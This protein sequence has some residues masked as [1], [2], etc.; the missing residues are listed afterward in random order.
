MSEGKIIAG[1]DIGTTKIAC[2]VGQKDSNGKI[3]I[4]GYGKTAS[5]GVTRGVVQNIDQTV[6]AIKV[7]V[8]EASDQANVDIQC[9]NVGIAGQHIRSLSH[10]ESI[11]RENRDKEITEEELESMRQRIFKIGVPPGEEIIDVIPQEYYV[12]GEIG[13]SPKGMLGSELSAN[14]HV[15]IGLKSAAMNIV[16]CIERAGLTMSN[17]ILEPIASADAVLSADEKEAGVALVDIGGG[18]TDIAIFYE[19]KIYHSAV[20]PFGGNVIS[21][22]ITKGCA[23]LHRYA[24]AVKVKFGSAL[25]NSERED[26]FVSIPGIYNQPA[27]EISLRNLASIIQARMDEILELV[28]QEI[29]RINSQ[30]P[31]IGGIV[32]TGGGSL[33]RN[34]D[35][36]TAF[37]TGLEVRIGYPNEYLADNNDKELA[38]PMYSTGIGL[39]IEGIQRAECRKVK[40]EPV[41]IETPHIEEPI[42]G[43]AEPV[44]EQPQTTKEP[45][46]SGLF[47]IITRFFSADEVKD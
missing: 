13:T 36:L 22:D 35:Q 43:N 38:S 3:K 9:V 25:A 40:K 8:K 2:I 12:D 47:R 10:K 28:N 20:I 42:R 5:T 7:A 29:Q 31:L 21:D 26:E 44:V 4:L 15:I 46:G 41:V 18:T 11:I 45:W 16:K 37:R 1:L 33:L 34:I 39:V 27:K 17:M 24:E 19:N 32:I 6:E 23:I 30:Y 14:F